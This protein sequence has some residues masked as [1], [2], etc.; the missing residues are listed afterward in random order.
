MRKD[1]A[2]VPGTQWKFTRRA[3]LVGAA[4]GG[5][6]LLA[7]GLSGPAIAAAP[8]MKL[9]FEGPLPV[10]A[11]SKPFGT[12]MD[13]G[14]REALARRYGYIEEE[15]LVSG[16][17]DVFGPGTKSPVSPALDAMD[18]IAALQALSQRVDV[19]VPFATRLIVLRPADMGKFSEVVHLNPFH[20]LSGYTGVERNLL[21]NGDVWMGMEVN[22]GTRFGVEERPSGGIANLRSFDPGRY[23]KLSIPA[24]KPA[25]WPDLTGNQLGEAYKTINFGRR[26]DGKKRES[27]LRIFLQEISRSYAQ[28]PDIMIKMTEALRSNAPGNPLHGHKVRRIYT[29]GASGQSTILCPFV[30]YHHER[31]RDLLGHVPFDGYMIKVGQIPTHRPSGAAFVGV[32]SE[33]EVVAVKPAHLVGYADSEEPMYRYYEIAGVGH[34]LTSRPNA[35]ERIG[36]L[37]PK[38]VSGISDIEG[39]TQFQPYDKVS[40]PVVWGMW[41]NIYDYVENGVSMPRAPRVDRDPSASDGIARDRFGNATGGLRL[42]WLDFPDARYVGAI[43]DENPLE[44][45][46]QPF[47]EAQLAKLYGSPAV[48][49]KKV[50]ARLEQMVRERWIEARDIPVMRLRGVSPALALGYEG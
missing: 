34:G 4:A 41:R 30:N 36:K 43:S 39:A 44:G 33:A 12:A 20:N 38:G 6:A 27:E 9:T 23:G 25:D 37:V 8:D 35:A 50:D 28:A 11:A 32:M 21:R 46:M 2:E 26:V 45:G 47:G 13:G 24:G 22:S 48:Y 40:V 14:A 10:T 19:A 7:G 3:A 18:V 49:S 1:A 31:A 16:V 17:A 15:Y 5:S 29:S 42:P